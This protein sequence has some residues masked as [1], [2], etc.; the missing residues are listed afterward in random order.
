MLTHIKRQSF[1]AAPPA[2]ISFGSGRRHCLWFCAWPVG[3]EVF[4]TPTFKSFCCTGAFSFF[5]EKLVQRL[6]LWQAY[7]IRQP[8]FVSLLLAA[9]VAMHAIRCCQ[10]TSFRANF[11]R[12]SNKVNLTLFVHPNPSHLWKPT[13]NPFP[14]LVHCSNAIHNVDRGRRCNRIACT[15]YETPALPLGRREEV[16]S[17]SFREFDQKKMCVT[18]A[19]NSILLI[20]I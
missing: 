7:S 4:L 3:V 5:G 9:F 13:L 8:I 20:K 18:I 1:P 11:C 17:N 19:K 6:A 10:L 14:F 15:E 16:R 2:T 12:E